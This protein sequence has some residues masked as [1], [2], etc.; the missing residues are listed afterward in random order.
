MSG[1]ASGLSAPD[2]TCEEIARRLGDFGKQLIDNHNARVVVKPK[3]SRSG[4]W[5]G[6]G[7]LRRDGNSGKLYLTGRYRNSGD[8]RY[9]I[10][11]G[12]RGLELALFVSVNGGRD[13]EKIACW[14]KKSLEADAGRVIS[15]EGSSLLLSDDSSARMYVSVERAREYPPG[16][17][18][19]RKEGTGV[20]GIDV[21]RGKSPEDL[22]ASG[23]RPLMEFTGPGSLH[24]KDPVTFRMNQ[25]DQML[26][27]RHPFSWS[28]SYTG[29]A[30]LKNSGMECEIVCN[31]VLPRGYSWDVAVSRI[32]ECL[33][34]PKKGFFSSLP[35]VSLYFYDGAECLREHPRNERGE[36]GPRGYSCEE[37]GGLAWGFDG[38][39]P[40]MF[41][42]SGNF[43]LFRSPEGTG[44]SRYVTACHDGEN[45]I[46]AWQRSAEDYSQP[47]VCNILTGKQVAE[48]LE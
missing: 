6:G 10:S 25:N 22:D 39:F 15:I 42:I 43:P 9:G 38:R 24:A 31:D 11:A 40:E 16:F 41:R 47:L 19:F 30:V 7:K 32:T 29:L 13:F 17:E 18:K 3:K 21:F 28:S 44:S 36:P 4:F 48:I 35:P 23:S 8:S 27:C 1:S 45:V 37:L 2:K 34:V 14:D 33:S 26:F 5:F 20:W 46:A 12:E